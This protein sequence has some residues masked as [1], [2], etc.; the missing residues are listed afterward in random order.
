MA[1]TQGFRKTNTGILEVYGIS[2]A[3]T[4]YLIQVENC[5]A[6]QWA[7]LLA[8]RKYKGGRGRPSRRVSK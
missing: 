4:P 3:N 6:D 8:Y 5:R 1:T 7:E 2:A